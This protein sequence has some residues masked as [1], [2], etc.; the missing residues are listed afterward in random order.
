MNDTFSYKRFN[1]LLKRQWA[2]K[3][4]YYT[5]SLLMLAGILTL[6]Y[7]YQLFTGINYG[8]PLVKASSDNRSFFVI[9]GIVVLMQV[10]SNYFADWSKNSVVMREL[11]N[12]ASTFEKLVVAFIYT[13]IG[14]TLSFI[15][16]FTL[17]DYGFVTYANSY[18]KASGVVYEYFY[19]RTWLKE[20][21][22]IYSL[23]FLAS[24]IYLLGSTSFKRNHF[25]LTTVSILC[26]IGLF[27]LVIFLFRTDQGHVVY[28][29]SNSSFK[30]LSTVNVL[31]LLCFLFISVAAYIWYIVFLKMKEKEV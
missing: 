30:M 29:G 12:P 17:I 5:S 1:L 27:I 15:L 31:Q 16:I 10:S 28:V 13:F 24:S 2:V 22:I 11:M 8:S 25:I 21:V 20:Q 4:K 3:R 26:L 9:G 23:P 19:E 14:T 18:A 7:G 6:I